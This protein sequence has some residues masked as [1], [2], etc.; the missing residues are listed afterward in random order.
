LAA[1]LELSRGADEIAVVQA[2]PDGEFES[3]TLASGQY[4]AR[5]LA[6]GYV[7]AE[8]ELDIP[9]HG[10]GSELRIALRSLRVVALDTYAGVAVRIVPEPRLR[11][12]TVRETLDAAISGGRAGPSFV[13]LA[14]SVEQMAYARPIPFEG[15]LHDLQRTA[16]AALEEIAERSPAPQD[17][18]LGQ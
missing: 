14:L 16:A 13:P 17:P 6:P 1:G 4:R 5:V 11:D 9:H 2:R 12:A 18:G 10:N 7:P 15:D 8:F 3:Q